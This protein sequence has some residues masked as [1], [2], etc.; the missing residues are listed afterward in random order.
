MNILDKIIAKKH[1]EVEQ[2]KQKGIPTFEFVPQTIPSLATCFNGK[3]TLNII[4]E[5]KRSSPSKGAI[6]M[7]VNPV[8]QAK[9][10]ASL[11]AG[12]ISVLTDQP[13]FNGSFADLA[14]VRNV[15]DLPIL[16][17]D[18][19]IDP[20]QIDAAKA[21]GASII[22]LIAAALTPDQFKRLYA[23][24]QAAQMDVLFE[25]HDEREMQFALEQ[26]V[27]IIGI[28]NRNLE[29]FEVDLQTTAKLA[30]MV[31]NQ[32]CTLI[33]ESGMRTKEDATFAANH[34]AQGILVGE[35]FMRSSQLELAFSRMQ[36]P[37]QKRVVPHAR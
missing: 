16:C 14:A 15:V 21:A 26:Q 34:G 18:F 32:D 24:A 6:Q 30:A 17:K 2:L 7:D 31:E 36:V 27:P 37:I 29:T 5:I 33:S 23:H 35:T 19:I 3:S 4:A 1:V 8:A 28:N 9:K 20:V 25:V 22:L 11:G 12:A 10:Y 13:F